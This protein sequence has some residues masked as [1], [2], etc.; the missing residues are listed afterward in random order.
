MDLS[1][2]NRNAERA[3]Y[4]LI[5]GMEDVADG[6]GLRLHGSIRFEFHLPREQTRQ[7]Q[8]ARPAEVLDFGAKFAR[9]LRQ[10]RNETSCRELFDCLSGRE[11]FMGIAKQILWLHSA[12]DW[13][14]SQWRGCETART[15]SLRERKHLA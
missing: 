5:P 4:V 15:N 2:R 9:S 13:L 6:L 12:G 3:G 14:K 11:R 8:V 10:H 7:Q 1:P